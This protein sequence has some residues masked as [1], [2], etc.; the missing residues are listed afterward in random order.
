MIYDTDKNNDDRHILNSQLLN[1]SQHNDVFL[2]IH[3]YL[4]MFTYNLLLL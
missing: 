2:I 1:L 3:I 4:V